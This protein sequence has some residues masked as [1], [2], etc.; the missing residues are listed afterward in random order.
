MAV[1]IT[2]TGEH[3]WDSTGAV[4][5]I[6]KVDGLRVTNRVSEESLQDYFGSNG[7]QNDDLAAFAAHRDR[8]EQIARVMIH[9]GAT[10][11][12]GGADLTTDAVEKYGPETL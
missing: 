12:T 8:I 9:A 10:N 1:K 7:S 6:A 2:F 4:V 5:F 11:V 3:A